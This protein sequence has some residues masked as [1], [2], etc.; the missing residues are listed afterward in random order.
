MTGKVRSE[1]AKSR[2]GDCE[3]WQ[4]ITPLGDCMTPSF[5]QLG[6]S[7]RRIECLDSLGFTDPT[8]IQ[9][10][11]IPIFLEGKDIIGQ[12]QTGTGKTAAFSL[13]ILERVDP[14]VKAVQALI[15]APTRELA[16]QVSQAMQTFKADPQLRVAAVYGG[17]AI[18][19]QVSQLRRGAQVVVGTPGRVM[20]L[21]DRGILNLSQVFCFVLDEADEMLNMGFIPDVTTILKQVPEERQTAFFSATMSPA[22][23]RLAKQFLRDPENIKAV[24]YTHLT[25]PTIYSV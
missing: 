7:E 5:Q 9:Q 6:L 25:L 24:S 20:D 4:A 22:I 1:A 8:P 2:T 11:A 15:L 21:I 18:D 3:E 16:V 14:A 23:H 12:A 13:P 17:Q 10:Q 19:V